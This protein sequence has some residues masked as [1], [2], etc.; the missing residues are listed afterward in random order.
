MAAL[1]A[2]TL[3][4]GGSR[5]C[6]ENTLTSSDTFTID[7]AKRAFMVLF[8]PTGS[9][10]TP[11]ISSTLPAF[12]LPG[13]MVSV[14]PST[15]VAVAVLAGEWRVINLTESYRMLD[16]ACTIASGTSLRCWIFKE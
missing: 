4:G 12:D 16:G 11:T 9:T 2:T 8:N 14:N 5:A 7:P 6:T 3:Q 15:G 1:T 13:S 10:I